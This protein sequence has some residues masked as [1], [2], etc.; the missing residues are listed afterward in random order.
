MKCAQCGAELRDTAKI[1]IN[2]GTVV[3]ILTAPE[4]KLEPP[5]PLGPTPSAVDQPNA[6]APSETS[7]S[8]GPEPFSPPISSG[9]RPLFE[10]APDLPPLVKNDS[11][12]LDLASQSNV[13]KSYVYA[14]LIVAA[15]LLLT[16][17]AILLSSKNNS[18][19]ATPP[20]SA[21]VP[22]GRLPSP[23]AS[24]HLL[25]RLLPRILPL[26][27]VLCP[28]Q[29]LMNYWSWDAINRGPQLMKK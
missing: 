5:L 26:K 15:I 4:V 21:T 22:P 13:K 27:P 6:T 9:S 2:C 3:K 20:A 12:S 19:N 10:P 14:G 7:T 29:C 28:R 24:S 1:C 23:D 11:A 16:T 18:S 17:L 8:S 25:I